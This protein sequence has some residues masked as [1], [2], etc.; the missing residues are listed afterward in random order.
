[1]S[2]LYA[3]H[4]GKGPALVL[5]HPVGLDGSSW[6][7]FSAGLEADYTVYRIDLPGHGQSS[8]AGTAGTLGSYADAVSAT[9][10]A[11]VAGPFVLMGLSFGGM[12]AQTIAARRP[13][14]L[15]GLL[16]CGCGCTFP[17]AARAGVRQRGDKALSLGMAGVVDETVSRWFTPG[18]LG[19]PAVAE[20]RA[21]LLNEDPASWATAW[22]AI[23]QLDTERDLEGVQV[24]TLC[25]AG[26]LDQGSPPEAVRRVAAGIPGSRYAELRSAPHMM[27]IETPGILLEAVRPFLDGLRGGE[28]LH[29]RNGRAIG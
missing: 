23:S 24:P 7:R 27:Q 28:Q 5:L 2:T 19:S 17:E 11:E 10:A 9:I 3:E 6:R 15:A 14:E 12:I 18:F 26:A 13:T 29:D 22:Q 4:S 20:V 8:L 25:I 1:M 16:V 21:E